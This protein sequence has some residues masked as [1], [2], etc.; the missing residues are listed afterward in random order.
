MIR[1]GP[2]A[3]NP[4]DEHGKTS[5]PVLAQIDGLAECPLPL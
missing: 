4:K 3:G 1:A 5:Q 2:T